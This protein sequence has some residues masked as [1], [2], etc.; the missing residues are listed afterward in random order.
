MYSFR[1]LHGSCDGL[2]SEEEL[3]RAAD[4]GY[5]CL[6]CRPITK[7]TLVGIS[8]MSSTPSAS[9]PLSLFFSSAGTNTIQ[10]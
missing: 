3:D 1:W 7:R 4:Y 2:M 5:H 6:F 8:G 10:G 9:H